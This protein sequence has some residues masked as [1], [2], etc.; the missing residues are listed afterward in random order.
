M[1]KRGRKRLGR[2]V[3]VRQGEVEKEK[4]IVEGRSERLVPCELEEQSLILGCLEVLGNVVKS[5]HS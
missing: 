3:G 2:L 4:M 1:R 5:L